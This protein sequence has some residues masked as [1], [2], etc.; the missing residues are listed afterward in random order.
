MGEN[1]KICAKEIRVE[2]AMGEE[3]EQ[4]RKNKEEWQWELKKN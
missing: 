3:K 1:Q 2:N 4:E